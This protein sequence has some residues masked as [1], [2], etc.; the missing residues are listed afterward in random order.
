MFEHF[1]ESTD[2][3]IDCRGKYVSVIIRYGSK[4]AYIN[5]IFIGDTDEYF[6]VKN[7]KNKVFYIHKNRILYH[8]FKED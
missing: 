1:E 6:I 3:K 8:I 7:S 4:Y 2:K 5:G